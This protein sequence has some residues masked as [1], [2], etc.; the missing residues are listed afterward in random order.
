MF[1]IEYIATPKGSAQPTLFDELALGSTPEEA[2][3]QADTHLPLMME[4]YGAKGYRI[5][6]R[7]KRCIGIG[8]VGFLD[9]G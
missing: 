8:P 3:D 4:K 7:E 5:I 1:I 9:A 6:D 2:K